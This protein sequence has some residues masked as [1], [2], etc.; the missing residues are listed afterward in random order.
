MAKSFL[1]N[2]TD[3]I[4]GGNSKTT[5]IQI[6]QAISR[7]N[8]E[9]AKLVRFKREFD[10]YT[11][12]RLVFDNASYR[13]FDFIRSLPDSSTWSQQAALAQSCVDIGRIHSENLQLLNKQIHSSI[14]LSYST[15]KAMQVR[16]DEQHHTQHDYDKTRRHYESSIKRDERMKV[17]RIKNE[18]DQLK[19]ALNLINTELRDDLPK[20]QVNLQNDYIKMIIE[21]FDIHAKYH[22]NSYK[23]YSRSIKNFHRDVSTSINDN[24]NDSRMETQ[25]STI[26]D[27]T[28]KPTYKQL[29]NSK[30]SDYKILHQARV[31][32]DYKAENEDEIDLIK[33]EY[34]SVILFENEEDNIRDKD[35]EYA[36]KSDGT[37]GLFPINFAV[38][39]YYN[40]E[41]Q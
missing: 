26:D 18:L 11:Q 13:F 34:I 37:I 6:V 29:S 7:F 27:E 15:F 2:V 9:H 22:K 40:E 41:K 21:L 36:K 30:R 4:T 38:R 35:W 32:H 28:T 1:R 39:L 25:S 33:D 31:I 20:F 16:I 14:D 19:S 23:L 8:D 10:K 5:D 12:A 3:Q 24:R 17:D